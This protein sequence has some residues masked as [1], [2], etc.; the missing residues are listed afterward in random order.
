MEVFEIRKALTIGIATAFLGYMAS[1]QPVQASDAKH[2]KEQNNWSIQVGGT[3]SYPKLDAAI[4]DVDAI[5]EEISQMTVEDV[6]LEN[7]DD[8]QK[9]TVGIGLFRRCAFDV[10]NHELVTWPG[11]YLAFANAEIETDETYTTPHGVPMGMDFNQEYT[12]YQLNLE[13]PVE[14]ARLEYWGNRDFTAMVGGVVSLNRFE[15]DTS[16]DTKIDAMGAGRTVRGEF[17]DHEVGLAAYVGAEFEISDHWSLFFEGRYDW[18]T[19]KGDTEVKDTEFS[20]L[21]SVTHEYDQETEIDLTGHSVGAFIRYN[22]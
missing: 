20:P 17:V 4:D 3:F 2:E 19:F 13:V 1:A 5:G 22:F 10:G 16:L 18:L 12:F 14:V 6:D 11:A 7:W 15:A 21:G 9:G 8:I